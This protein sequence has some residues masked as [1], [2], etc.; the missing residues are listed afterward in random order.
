MLLSGG[1]HGKSRSRA[2][3]GSTLVLAI[4]CIALLA[5]IAA[6]LVP[7]ALTDSGVVAAG[8]HRNAARYSAEKYFE[9]G[10]S[11]I[12][13]DTF[14]EDGTA[15]NND[16]GDEGYDWLEDSFGP[17]TLRDLRDGV[18]V[19]EGRT[20]DGLTA[21]V[22][23][24]IIDHESLA[25]INVHG[26]FY[27]P[28][29]T[30]NVGQGASTGEIALERALASVE[31]PE[32]IFPDRSEAAEAT[33]KL[34]RQIISSARFFGLPQYFPG[35]ERD[36]ID[37]HARLDYLPSA[38]P[39]RTGFAEANEFSRGLNDFADNTPADSAFPSFFAKGIHQTRF[40]L[41]TELA[42][43]YARFYP[44]DPGTPAG[45]VEDFARDRN[46]A[47]LIGKN[48][49]YLHC[50]RAV[51]GDELKARALF[52]AI[53]ERVTTVSGDPDVSAE[54]KPRVCLNDPSQENMERIYK[55]LKEKCP[56]LSEGR[57]RQVTANLKAY[58]ISTGTQPVESFD[59]S[60]RE[61][62]GLARFPQFSEVYFISRKKAFYIEIANPF[63]TRQL[64]P[65]VSAKDI[66]ID[67]RNM[68]L[69]VKLRSG[70]DIYTADLNHPGSYIRRGEP[71]DPRK[72]VIYKIGKGSKSI[73]GLTLEPAVTIESPA[74]VEYIELWYK[75]GVS[76]PFPDGPLDRIPSFVFDTCTDRSMER[77]DLLAS[78]QERANWTESVASKKHSL[79]GYSSGEDRSF[80][81]VSV[82]TA[83]MPTAPY[84]HVGGDGNRF[85]NVGEFFRL[86][87][88]GPS[89]NPDTGKPFDSLMEFVSFIGARRE[90]EKLFA[91]LERSERAALY[92]C[93]TAFSPLPPEYVNPEDRNV[94]EGRINI[95]TACEGVLASLPFVGMKGDKNHIAAYALVREFQDC[96]PARR[97][98]DLIRLHGLDS[99]GNDVFIPADRFPANF[100]ENPMPAD[101][102]DHPEEREFV[103]G[104]L[105]NM[106][107]A[108]SNMFTLY[109]KVDIRSA[110]GQSLSGA[111]L[112]GIVDR[113]RPADPDAVD[114][115]PRLRVIMRHF[116]DEYE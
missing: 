95:N 54:L 65:A 30:T 109:V 41:D 57:I 71:D 66:A 9:Y 53:A 38:D 5:A 116:L 34:A 73:I 13:G 48:R 29:G 110:G 83:D 75:K 2:R 108:R 63:N 68:E 113:S 82:M 17:Y 44:D 43:Q 59:Y 7:L 111:R 14:G 106:V 50:L 15:Y 105:E 3:R 90:R 20:D 32:S 37:N 49:L 87:T 70:P 99:G 103:A 25:N 100:E 91:R 31:L 85:A 19:F 51:G 93:L 52:A 98:S 84:L 47:T 97:R 67:M 40:G 102:A 58:L 10:V 45:R 42:I 72:T 61:T 74:D 79:R 1:R 64:D 18:T 62:Y 114:F 4:I 33:H 8:N 101:R 76:N 46:A 16:S 78:S 81:S 104:V 96:R 23:L 80:N 86:L 26:N 112:V 77:I 36:R 56:Y 11:L 55:L 21:K 107:T 28:G 22:T 6:I 24:R 69:R 27:G 89:Y 60:F 92:D 39:N 94:R 35:G 88:V 12:Y 115:R